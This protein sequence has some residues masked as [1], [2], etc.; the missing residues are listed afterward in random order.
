MDM[1][2][3]NFPGAD[4]FF[5]RMFRKVDNVVWDLMS[6]KI[7]VSTSDG[8]AV[9][10]GTSVDDYRVEK[11][12]MDDFGVTLPAF[13]QSTPIADVK[14]GDIIFRNGADT[15]IAWIIETTKNGFKLMKPSG[16]MVN[17]VPPKVSVFGLESGIMVVR[18]LMSMVG[19]NSNLQSMQGSLLPL[20]MMGGDMDMESIMPMMLWSGAMNQPAADGTANPFGGNMMQTMMLM[21]MMKGSGKGNSVFNGSKVSG[22]DPYASYSSPKKS[23]SPFRTGGRD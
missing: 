10:A 2:S 6:G 7:G 13:A 17:W 14:I 21:N 15:S 19:G 1:K 22:D 8:I 3:F 9:L 5:S 20:L 4:K 16:E 18:S 23:S 12:L 11:N